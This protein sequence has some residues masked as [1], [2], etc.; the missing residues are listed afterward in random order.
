MSISNLNY[1]DY[2]YLISLFLFSSI[3]GFKGATKSISYTLKIILS[4]SIPFLFYKRI[5][6][7]ILV[8]IN[9]EKLLLLQS[10]NPI[11]LE[12][13]SFITIF[14]FTYLAFSIL[15]KALNLKSPSQ[16]EFKILDI[17]F[18]A[19]Y[20]ILL[21]SMIF[22]FIYITMLKKHIDE[23]NIIMKL[24]ISIYE[25]LMYKDNQPNDIKEKKLPEKDKKNDQNKL[26]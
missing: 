20:G 13:V 22:Y 12:I 14:L 26:Y 7:F 16:L 1:V 19:I 8:K 24:N 18:G 9:S 2:I 25:N 5:L 21:F 11:F 3:F 23:N 6:N 15:E 4:V 10:N 17:V